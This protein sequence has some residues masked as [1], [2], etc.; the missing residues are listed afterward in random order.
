M[1]RKNSTKSPQ[2]SKK[3]AAKYFCENCSHEVQ[4]NARFCPHCGKFFSSVRCPKCGQLGTVKDFKNGC[5]KCHYSMTTEELYGIPNSDTSS[6]GRKHKLSR[7][8]K[9]RIKKAFKAH[10]EKI[11]SIDAGVPMWLFVVLFCV[12]I[13]LVAIIFNKCQ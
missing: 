1:A 11:R 5:P 13:A 7:K 3:P 9:T 10:G 2:K 6:D 4:A 8:S 12:L